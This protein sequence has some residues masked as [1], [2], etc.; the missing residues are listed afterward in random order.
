MSKKTRKGEWFN[1]D[2]H[3]DLI[4]RDCVYHA[5]SHKDMPDFFWRGELHK[6]AAR[7]ELAN[8]IEDYLINTS[9]QTIFAGRFITDIIVD[10]PKTITRQVYMNYITIKYAVRVTAKTVNLHD[11]DMVE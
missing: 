5:V 11:I 4:T 9:K 2:I 10:F 1:M 3:A 7:I 6:A 8:E